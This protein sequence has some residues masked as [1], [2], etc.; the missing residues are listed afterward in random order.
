MNILQK[1]FGKKQVATSPVDEPLKPINFDR[2]GKPANE[3]EKP[4]STSTKSDSKL[5]GDDVLKIFME[6]AKERVQQIDTSKYL[7]PKGFNSVKEIEAS[8]FIALVGDMTGSNDDEITAL[9]VRNYGLDE[10]T[11]R[12][13]IRDYRNSRH[14]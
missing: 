12:S 2:L 13:I 10:T 6:K 3:S 7:G 9:V 4:P 5:K 8:I 1:L 14:K 11:T